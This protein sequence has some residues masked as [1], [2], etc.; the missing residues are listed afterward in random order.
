MSARKTTGTNLTSADI[1]FTTLGLGITHY[2]SDHLKMLIY[3]DIVRNEPTMLE[4]WNGDVRDNVFTW[5]IQMR[6]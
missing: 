1:K 2:F 3:Y 4:G 5:R 6:F